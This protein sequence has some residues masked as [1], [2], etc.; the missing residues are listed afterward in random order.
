MAF[1]PNNM[2]AYEILIG[3]IDGQQPSDIEHRHGITGR[4]SISNWTSR[5]FGL[6]PKQLVSKVLR[7]E[8]G[9]A[10]GDVSYVSGSS[11][12]RHLLAVILEGEFM[13]EHRSALPRGEYHIWAFSGLIC[14]QCSTHYPETRKVYRRIYQTKKPIGE[15]SDIRIRKISPSWTEYQVTPQDI[16]AQF[17][18]IWFPN[19][20]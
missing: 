8:L 6:T 18:I 13:R 17:G 1:T 12:N 14:V 7:N 16:A 10:K 20:D 2:F 11:E 15:L 3:L 5:Q 19:E 4:T 9:V